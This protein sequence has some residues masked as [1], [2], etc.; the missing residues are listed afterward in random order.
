MPGC[1]AYRGENR[2]REGKEKAKGGVLGTK[3]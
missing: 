2:K 3:V 1:G